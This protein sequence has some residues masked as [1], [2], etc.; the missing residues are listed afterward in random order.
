MNSSNSSKPPSSDFPSK[1]KSLRRPSGK[2]AGGQTGHKGNGFKIVR[3][4]DNYVSHEPAQCVNCDFLESCSRQMQVVGTR[5]EVD[6]EIIP[7]ITAHQILE[8]NCP[9]SEK[10]LRG[11][12]PPGITSTMQYGINLETLVLALNVVGTMSIGRIHEILS[13]VFGVPISTGTIANMLKECAKS[14]SEP[15]ASIKNELL[16]EP[17]LHFDETGLR[18]NGKLVWVHVA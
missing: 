18:V 15:L 4:P 12:Y 5:N 14:I 9:R 3:K 6:I 11:E 7:L 13:D 1:P 10:V 17:I 8:V 2:K 16:N